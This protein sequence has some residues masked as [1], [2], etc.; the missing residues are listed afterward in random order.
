MRLAP[1]DRITAVLRAPRARPKPSL[2]WG[3]V[4]SSSGWDSG[5][6]EDLGRNAKV[7]PLAARRS[8]PPR[9]WDDG[10]T[11]GAELGALGCARSSGELRRS[12]QSGPRSTKVTVR[13]ERMCQSAT[14]DEAG[15]EQTVLGQLADP[16]GA[17]DVGPPRGIA[18]V[19]GVEKPAVEL[20]F[21][22]RRAAGTHMQC[23]RHATPPA[24]I[25]LTA[26]R[27]TLSRSGSRP[28]TRSAPVRWLGDQP[29]SRTQRPIKT[30]QEPWA[31]VAAA[32]MASTGGSSPVQRSSWAAAW[33]TSMPIPP[34]TVAP[35]RAAAAIQA[36]SA[37]S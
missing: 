32:H 19:S 31:A 24:V 13:S 30:H 10:T 29:A 23:S 17:A 11:E 12:K 27:G 8:R 35:R 22:L 7:R 36:V 15:A 37:G 20:L 34:S 1:Q 26:W 9:R 18:H 5:W 6:L 2:N 33:W 21:E 14:N 16:L 28:R 4:T 25:L 3:I